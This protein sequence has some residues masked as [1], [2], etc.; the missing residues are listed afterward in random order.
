MKKSTFKNQTSKIFALLFFL[1]PTLLPAMDHLM[2]TVTANNGKEKLPGAIVFWE[3]TSQ[4][5]STDSVGNFMLAWPDSFPSTLIVRA[6][7]YKT[8]GLKFYGKNPSTVLINLV[9]ATD[10]L[11][12]VT[13]VERRDASEF[14][15]ISPLN[16]ERITSTGLRKAACCNLSESFE[17]NP[18]VDASVTDAVSGAKK[19]QLLGLDGVYSQILFENL[20]LIRGLSSSYGLSY[21]PGTW[22]N[23]ILVTKGT[24]SVVNGYES[25]AG[26]LNIDLLKPEEGADKYFVNVYGN[27][28]GRMEANFHVNRMIGKNWGTTLLTH[29]STLQLRNDMNHDGFLDMP[30]YTQYNAL[31]R[32][33]WTTN[34]I[35]QGEFGARF[36][37]EDRIGGQ[38]E[39]KR[40][41]DYGTTNF[42]GVG[43]KNKQAEFFN[44]TGF[45]FASPARSLGTMF[46]AR[47]HDQDMF[48]GLQKYSGVQQ[49][50]YANVI[51]QD[52]I[53][54]TNHMYKA[55]MSFVYDDYRES[56]NDSAFHRTEIVPGFFAE[57]TGH[58]SSKFTLVAGMRADFHNL[59][60]FQFTP[61]LHMKYDITPKTAL[62]I[63]GGRGFRTANI[64][65]ENSNV[66][67]SSRK[68]IVSENLKP[69]IAWNYGGSI[70][71]K[72]TFLKNDA[73]LI[74]DFFRTDFVNQ[75]VMDME[76]PGELKF[77]NLNGKSFANSF[78]AD[79]MIEPIKRFDVRLAYKFYDVETNFGGIQKQKPL[80]PWSRAFINLAYAMPYDKWTFDFTTKWI[81][82]TRLPATFT[83]G[84]KFSKPYAVLS[85]N[86][87]RKFPR[88]DVYGGVEN[89]L[90]FKQNNPIIS[91]NDPFG[92]HFDASQLYAPTDGRVIYAGLR[93]KL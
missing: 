82:A 66:F 43:I 50:L 25:I 40:D 57:Y 60:G 89:I 29:A 81:G 85:T 71:Q 51:W 58:L 48:F 12:A 38:T 79:L 67:A 31:N 83:D 68:L 33:T 62:R 20:P 52:M 3:G 75:V 21:V 15:F 47:L 32:W 36:V 80:T 70:Q 13:I 77:Y 56:F 7:G 23:G 63:S 72:F 84:E 49:S 39:F 78:Q 35:A 30:L 64:F 24:G 10:T 86:I 8:K 42:Y 88:F 2:G 59:A 22:I 28:K 61:R 4:G 74:V 44:K 37:Y 26:Q 46:T 92:P 73:T 53:G 45:V 76:T 55:G 34:K 87:S 65:T 17:T 16:I 1:L 6:S 19:I 11:S 14:S 69:E 91:A 18:T 9:A 93:F 27:D 5:T 54:N 41:R 90:N